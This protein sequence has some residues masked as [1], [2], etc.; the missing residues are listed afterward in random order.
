MLA[1]GACCCLPSALGSLSF[2]DFIR[3]LSDLA[4]RKY[5]GLSAPEAFKA[6]YAEVRLHA[7]VNGLLFVAYLRS[8]TRPSLLFPVRLL[9][10]FG[11]FLRVL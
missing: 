9:L 4:C 1:L 8:H 3:A 5:S 11:V 10:W 6:L 7:C 2:D